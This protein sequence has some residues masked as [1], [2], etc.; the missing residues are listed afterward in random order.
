MH[1]RALYAVNTPALDVM[2]TL[3]TNEHCYA[4]SG[5]ALQ[6]LGRRALLLRIEIAPSPLGRRASRQ[7][8]AVQNR[9]MRFCRTPASGVRPLRWADQIKRP[10]AWWG[11]FVGA[12]EEIAPSVLGRRA[13]SPASAVQ[14]R[15]MRFCRT[16]DLMVRGRFGCIWVLTNQSLAALAESANSLS[17]AHSW[18][19]KFDLDTLLSGCTR[20]VADDGSIDAYLMSIRCD[21]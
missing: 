21:D 4:E 1:L 13:F 12:P 15:S 9:S 19:T 18:H 17:M 7:L 14:N 5:C 10:H 6:I 3:T 16:P 11:L 20:S 2:A 8:A